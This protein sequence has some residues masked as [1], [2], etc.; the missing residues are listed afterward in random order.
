MTENRGLC[1]M[2]AKNI[3]FNKFKLKKLNTNKTFVI[4]RSQ[5]MEWM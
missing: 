3:L 1:P 5:T 4:I 2:L